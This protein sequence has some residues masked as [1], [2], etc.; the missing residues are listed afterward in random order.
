M[1]L[2]SYAEDL[3]PAASGEESEFAAPTNGTMDRPNFLSQNWDERPG[4]LHRVR[5]V[6]TGR[7]LTNGWPLLASTPAALVLMSVGILR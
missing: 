2:S 1:Q 4:A 5:N 6:N 3:S 7:K